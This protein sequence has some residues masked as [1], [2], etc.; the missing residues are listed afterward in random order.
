[1][2]F[3][4]IDTYLYVRI[5]VWEKLTEKQHSTRYRETTRARSR[6]LLAESRGA[7][8]VRHVQQ[9]APREVD[10]NSSYVEDGSK[11]GLNRTLRLLSCKRQKMYTCIS[12]TFWLMLVLYPIQRGL[13][14]N[15]YVPQLARQII[16]PPGTEP[17]L[18]QQRSEDT[19]VVVQLEPAWL[20]GRCRY[21]GAP[22]PT[23]RATTPN[24]TQESLSF[25]PQRAC[26]VGRSVR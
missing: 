9:S 12:F 16:S 14:V 21:L 4:Q 5:D 11:P 13:N 8:K 18:Q 23:R 25:C 7:S 2:A 20:V 1:M 17:S 15:A 6:P 3:Y 22:L 26:S 19:R 10:L 24:V